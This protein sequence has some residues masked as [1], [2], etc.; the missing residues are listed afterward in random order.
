MHGIGC[1]SVLRNVRKWV[2]WFTGLILRLSSGRALSSPRFSF[3]HVSARFIHG[4]IHGK[5]MRDSNDYEKRGNHA[6]GIFRVLYA[7]SFST[8]KIKHKNIGQNRRIRIVFKSIVLKRNWNINFKI[9]NSDLT[10]LY[11]NFQVR[12]DTIHTRTHLF[13]PE[14]RCH[15]LIF[16]ILE[17]KTEGERSFSQFSLS[18][19]VTFYSSLCPIG[20]FILLRRSTERV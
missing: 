20:Y 17:R 14:V 5:T 12:F 7:A 18:S 19:S 11:T 4:I 16:Q 2:A 8:N 15:D 13:Y 9:L 1:E 10:Q 3:Y 6:S